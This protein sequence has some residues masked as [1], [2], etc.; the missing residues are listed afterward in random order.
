MRQSCNWTQLFYNPAPDEQG[1]HIFWI[2]SKLSPFCINA[3]FLPSKALSVFQKCSSLEMPADLI[4]LLHLNM[5]DMKSPFSPSPIRFSFSFFCVWIIT[6]K[7]FYYIMLLGFLNLKACFFKV[8]KS[9]LSHL[10]SSPGCLCS[11]IMWFVRQFLVSSL[12]PHS[13]HLNLSWITVFFTGS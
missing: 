13:S 11:L 3:Y 10:K 2:N 1:G 6:I 7:L 9:I 8:K 4:F 5:F 12:S